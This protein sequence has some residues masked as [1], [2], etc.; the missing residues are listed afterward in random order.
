[1]NFSFRAKLFASAIALSAISMVAMPVT[2]YGQEEV[3]SFG[4]FHAA[5]AVYGDW[6][7]SDRG[8][9]FGYQQMCPTIFILIFQTATG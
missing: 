5:L 6:V 3:V 4:A 8:V 2:S 1:M 9:K 7:Y